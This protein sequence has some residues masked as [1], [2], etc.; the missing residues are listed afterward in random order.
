MANDNHLSLRSESMYYLAAECLI[1]QGDLQ[2][3]LSRIDRVRAMRIENY[4]PYAD[5]AAA[6]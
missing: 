5:L 2:G 4:Q 1:R 6:S 3:G